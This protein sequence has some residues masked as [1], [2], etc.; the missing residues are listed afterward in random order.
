M[1]LVVDLSGEDA[2]PSTALR[3]AQDDT[4]CGY[5]KTSMAT[6]KLLWLS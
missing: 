5:N 3:F 2:G 4:F 6:A 1:F